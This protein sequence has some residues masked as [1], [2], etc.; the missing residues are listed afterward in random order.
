MMTLASKL[1]S[2]ARMPSGK[3]PE[4]CLRLNNKI[5]SMAEELTKWHYCTHTPGKVPYITMRNAFYSITR[6]KV[7]CHCVKQSKVHLGLQLAMTVPKIV[8]I[9]AE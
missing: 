1:T 3:K 7:D 2:Q 9:T 5:R 6:I 8:Q 4:C